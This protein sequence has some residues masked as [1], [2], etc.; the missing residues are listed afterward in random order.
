MLQLSRSR[1]A[2][3]FASRINE[4]DTRLNKIRSNFDGRASDS[5]QIRS[6]N[7]VGCMTSSSGK[8]CA[9]MVVPEHDALQHHATDWRRRS[10]GGGSIK[11]R[12]KR[13]ALNGEFDKVAC[14]RACDAWRPE[15]VETADTCRARFCRLSPSRHADTGNGHVSVSKRWGSRICMETHCRSHQKDVQSYIHCGMAYCG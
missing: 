6:T 14:S 1:S 9:D 15:S 8:S 12:R 3:N 4:A 11:S 13:W 2:R 7:L 10:S 5:R